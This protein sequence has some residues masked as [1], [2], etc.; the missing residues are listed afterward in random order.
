M[1][2][3]LLITCLTLSAAVSSAQT[4]TLAY[5]EGDVYVDAQRIQ[6]PDFLV[7]PSSVVRTEK[8]RA[9]VHFGRGDAVFLGA[10]SS[11]TAGPAGLEIL[12]GSAVVITGDIGPAVSCRGLVHLS[13]AGV[14]RFD[15]HIVVDEN[16]CKVRVYK[17][18][19]AAPLLSYVW[20]LTPGKMVDLGSCGD[21]TPRD[22]FNIEDADDLTRW[23]R[24]R[25]GVRP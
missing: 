23:S 7:K 15:R 4:V 22:E 8:G 6:Q 1:K 11:I 16:F 5:V 18:A 9:E 24:E 2:P 21:F 14:F 13:D 17:G 20:L 19:A 3:P 25:A 12:T 10:N